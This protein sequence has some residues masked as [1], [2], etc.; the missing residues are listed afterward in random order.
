M[1]GRLNIASWALLL[2]AGGQYCFYSRLFPSVPASIIWLMLFLPWL[3]AFVITSCKRPPFGP[4][5]FRLSLLI[6]MSWYT[7]VSVLAEALCFF[8]H[9]SPNFG[10][11]SVTAARILMYAGALSFMPFIRAYVLLRRHESDG[12]P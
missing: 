9:I 12:K 1:L 8:D 6:I 5:P 10:H 7:I 11:I 2:G 4:R 3:A